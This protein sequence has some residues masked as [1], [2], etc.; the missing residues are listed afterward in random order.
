M[1]I[2][3]CVVAYNE[4]NALPALLECIKSQDYPHNQMEVVLIDSKS[5]D[6][7]KKIM[8]KFRDENKDFINVQVLDNPRKIQAAGWNVAI[9]N[10]QGDVII[11]VDAHA[12]IPHDFVQKNAEVLKSGEYVSGGVRPN[13]IDESTPWK[14]TLLLAEQS[15]FGSSIAPYRRSEKKTYVKSVFHG[16]YKREVF[17]KVGLFN[18]Q[19]GRTE[20]NEIHYRIR[21]AGY[22]ICYSSDIISYQHTRSSLKAMLKQKYGN[23]YW[24]ALTLKACPKCLS[25]YHFVPFCFVLGIIGT[26]ILAAFGFPFLA[27]LMWGMYWLAAVAMSVLSVKGVK[28]TWCQLALPFLFF[29]LH[30]S[31]G[32]GSLV[33][34]VK[35]PF[36]KY[37]K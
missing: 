25:V 9:E 27:Y 5:E 29:L 35:L 3:V 23:G 33:G 11:R 37:K 10:Y 22:K 26:S 36:W 31:Y 28:K 8:E 7:T 34:M 2:S 18:E 4:Q 16:A 24:V 32:I 20:D 14:E 30:V 1:I 21:Q 6:A 19:L 13:M 12:A 15:M 17:D